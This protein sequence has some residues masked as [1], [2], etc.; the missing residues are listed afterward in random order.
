SPARASSSSSSWRM[1]WPSTPP[2]SVPTSSCTPASWASRVRVKR[3]ARS[4]R[5]CAAESGNFLSPW[6]AYL[7]NSS[8]LTSAV[9]T[10]AQAA[11][12]A[13]PPAGAADQ[14][15]PPGVV[16]VPCAGDAARARPAHVRGVVGELP[17]PLAGV[18]LELVDV[19]QRGDH[20]DAG[21]GGS[22]DRLVGQSRG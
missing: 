22:G 1:P 8:T 16:G 10:G 13:L 18:P 5:M 19:D 17:L 20:G 11:A 21:R 6:R 12:A 7:S 3:P 14:Q 9:T 15:P 4:R 2:A